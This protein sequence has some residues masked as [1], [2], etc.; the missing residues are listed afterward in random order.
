MAVR[1]QDPISQSLQIYRQDV[2]VESYNQFGLMVSDLAVAGEIL[3]LGQESEGKFIR[4]DLEVLPLPSHTFRPEQPIYLYYEVY[5]LLR[6]DTGQTHYRVD[7]SVEGGSKNAGARLLRGLGNLLGTSEE[8][9]GIQVSYEHRGDS[10]REPV[11]VALD[12]S[13]K[14][15]QKLTVGVTVTDLNRPGKVTTSKDVDVVVGDK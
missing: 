11:Y 15:G 7:Y 12:I 6:D 14:S 8:K 13:A 2:E 4:G 10:E 5:N 1:V 3:E 9:E